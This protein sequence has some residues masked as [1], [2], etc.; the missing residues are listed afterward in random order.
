MDT[1]DDLALN[2][3]DIT[4]C[5]MVLKNE[6]EYANFMIKNGDKKL[7]PYKNVVKDIKKTHEKILRIIENLKKG[8]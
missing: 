5:E 4:I 2:L 1:K 6:L 7:S 3:M 8:V